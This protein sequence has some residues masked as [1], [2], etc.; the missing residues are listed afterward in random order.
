MA[1]VDPELDARW[2]AWLL[3]RNRRGLVSALWIAGFLYPLFGVLDFLTAPR[4]WLWLLWGTRALVTLV[5]LVMFRLVRSSLFDRHPDLVSAGYMALLSLGISLMTVFMGGLSS[6]YYAGLSLTIVATGLLYVWPLK[7]VVLTHATIIASY[8]LPNLLNDPHTNPLTAISNQLFLV[9][10]AIIVGTG[11]RLAYRAQRRQISDQLTIEHTKKNLEEAH[12]QLKQLDRFKSEFFANITHELKTPL[13][14]MLAPLELL[15]DGQL[16]AISDSQRSTLASIERSGIKLRRLIGDLLDLSRLE[17]SKLRLRVDRYDLVQFLQELVAQAEPLIQRKSLWLEFRSNVQSSGVYC[18]IERIERVLVNLL[19]NATKFTPANGHVTVTLTDEGPSVLIEV[20]DTGIGFPPGMADNIFRRFFQVDS[21]STRRYGG[22]GIG[23]A[24]A[25]ELVE[26]HGGRIWAR[27]EVDAGA[28]VSVWLPKDREHFAPEALDRR[29]PRSD[30]LSGSR[31]SDHGLADWHIDDN[32]RHRLIDIDQASDLRVVERDFDEEQRPYSVLVVEDTPDVIRVIRLA[33]HHDFRIL[34]AP[35]GVK[36]LELARKHRPTVIVTDLMMPELDGLGL[37]R[38]LRADPVTRHIPIVMLTAR[39]DVS[40][41]IRGI[42]SGVNAYLAKPFSSKE[43]ISTVRAQLQSQEASAE[44]LLEQKLDSLQTLAGGLAHEIRNPLNY[45]QG[46]ISALE[47]DV[48]R[49]LEQGEKNEGSLPPAV[50]ERTQ[51]MFATARSGVKRIGGTVEL[52]MRYSR[53]GYTRSLQPYDLY[54]AL[55]DVVALLKSTAAYDVQTTVELEGE[56]LVSCVPE[57]MNQVLTN[58][59]ENAFQ[60]VPTDGS[61]RITA[62]GRNAGAMLVLSIRDNGPGIDPADVPRLFTAFFTRKGRTGGTGLGL[63]I[64]RRVVTS[65]RGTIH[66]ESQ[67]GAG[68]EFVIRVPR[69][70]AREHKKPLTEV[71]GSEMTP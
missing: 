67:P 39:G 15:I 26:L 42:D 3:E 51:K 59:L 22:T 1:P 23:L 32:E 33:L 58:L 69:L 37:T 11:Q 64:V 47:T 50:A 25:K 40:D 7:V 30:H 9:S 70:N 24:L 38:E 13:T 63:T 16:G 52:M 46:A 54:P 49:L 55:R 28:T 62:R 10:T 68:A 43:L 21:S 8:I 34:A 36:G 56:A 18:D 48:R 66:V 65:L 12:E 5:T 31:S 6:P 27:G 53:E 45:L 4:G 2:A 14:M 61:G 17:E 71:T 20:V 35:N 29:G 44:L 19:S 60:A 57:E 41:R